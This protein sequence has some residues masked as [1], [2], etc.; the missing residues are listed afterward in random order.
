MDTISMVYNKY[1][2]SYEKFNAIFGEGNWAINNFLEQSI[3]YCAFFEVPFPSLIKFDVSKETVYIGFNDNPTFQTFYEKN[4]KIDKTKPFFIHIN[5]NNNEKI[6]IRAIKQTMPVNK[7]AYVLL[8]KLNVLKLNVLQYNI[9]KDIKEG[10]TS[11]NSK[12]ITYYSVLNTVVVIIIDTIDKNRQ[13]KDKVKENHMKAI[14]KIDEMFSINIFEKEC[15]ALNNF[16][17]PS[18]ILA[19]ASADEGS[20]EVASMETST[21]DDEPSAKKAKEDS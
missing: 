14:A 4:P 17:A 13:N 3:I 2:K 7:D 5:N 8:N 9:M 11:N 1:L 16:N 12:H 10:V 21:F 18:S 6:I 15:I 20:T 19:T